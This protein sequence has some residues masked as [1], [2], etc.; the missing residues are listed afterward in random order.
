MKDGVIYT[1]RYLFKIVKDGKTS[2]H[3]KLFTDLKPSVEA[4]EKVLLGLEG[5]ESLAREYVCEYD[6]QFV[7]FVDVLKKEVV[8][9]S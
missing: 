3:F 6:P 9:E 4:F 8:K 1:Y 7:G 2:F 5:L